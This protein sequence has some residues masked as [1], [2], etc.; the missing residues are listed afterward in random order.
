MPTGLQIN[1]TTGEI[2]GTPTVEQTGTDATITATNGVSPDDSVTISFA[3]VVLIAP[4]FVPSTQPSVTSNVGASFTLDLNATGNPA[5]TYS[6]TNLPSG[7]NIDATTGLISGTFTTEQTRTTTITASNGVSPDATVSIQFTVL[8]ALAAPQ[9]TTVV[10]GTQTLRTNMLYELQLEATGFPTSITWGVTSGTLPNNVILNTAT[11]EIRGTP[12]TDQSASAVVITASNGVSPDATITITFEVVTRIAPAFGAIA[13]QMLVVNMPYT[14]TL[15]VT[16]TPTPVVTEQSQFLGRAISSANINLAV[17][18]WRGGTRIGDRIHFVRDT[19]NVTTAYDFN[20]GRQSSDDITLTGASSIRGIVSTDDRIYV[21]S[22]NGTSALAFNHSGGRVSGDDIDLS[23]FGTGNRW[24]GATR[25]DSLIYFVDNIDD[26]ARAYNFDRTRSAENDISLGEGAWRS[27]LA[28]RDRIY[29]LNDGNIEEAQG[30]D[31]EGNRQTGF[32]LSFVPGFW[33]ASAASD[34][35]MWFVDNSTDIAAAYISYGSALP[36]GVTY[37]NGVVSGTPT[38]V[39]QDVDITFIATNSSGDEASAT[40]SFEVAPTPSAPQITAPTITSYLYP[41]GSSVALD[42]VA[43][44]S[45]QVSLWSVTSGT[46]PS[47]LSFSSTSGN[48]VQIVGTVDTIYPSAEVVITASN[49]VDPDATVNIQ[50]TVIAALFAPQFVPA[51]QPAFTRNV[52]DEFTLDLNATG[53]PTPTYSS[54]NLPNGLSIDATTGVITGTFATPQTITSTITATNSE[55]TDTVTISF[56]V[57]ALV[58]PSLAAVAAQSYTIHTAITPVTLQAS[59][60]PT[61]VI[62]ERRGLPQP[63]TSDFGLSSG[64]WRGAARNGNRIYF[65]RTGSTTLFAYDLQ[66]GRQLGDDITVTGTNH[67]GLVFTD[68]RIFLVDNA[69]STAFAFDHSG[70]EVVGDNINIG[71]GGWAGASRR[72]DRIYFLDN[73][74]NVIRVYT[75]SGARREAEDITVQNRAYRSILALDDVI[76]VIADSTNNAYPYDYSGAA[77]TTSLDLGEGS[78]HG[79]VWTPNHQIFFVNAADNTAHAY[80]DGSNLP[81]GVLINDGVIS[82]TPTAVFPTTTATFQAKNNVLP[83]ATIDVPFTVTAALS[84]PQITTRTFPTQ[85]YR[86]GDVFPAIDVNATGN[87]VPTWSATNLPPGLQINTTTGV[88]TGT[89]TALYATAQATITASN[90]VG[91]DDSITIEFTVVDALFAPTIPADAQTSYQLYRTTPFTLDLD[92][93]GATGNPA[94]TWS[95][96]GGTLPPGLN[97]SGTTLSGTPTTEGVQVVTFTASN[98]VSPSA[99]IDITFTVSP[100]LVAPNI[101]TTPF[102]RTLRVG[103]TITDI[104]LNATGNPAPDWSAT[105]L[106]PGLTFSPTTGNNV[107]ITGTPTTQQDARQA[108]ITARNSVDSDT[109]SVNFTVLVAFSV[110]VIASDALTSYNFVTGDEIDDIVIR[111]TGNPLPQWSIISGQLPT[112]VE[113]GNRRHLVCHNKGNAY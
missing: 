84:A 39:G 12:D 80:S 46:L 3:V 43:T 7:L 20:G 18:V 40:V 97:F 25:T 9:I 47:G 63:L 8:A 90:G 103:Q 52:G 74:N 73:A 15:P 113:L 55:D 85:S 95:H 28:L 51:T 67:E 17:G 96:T 6:A 16:G 104:P 33:H 108:T 89:F 101:T 92:D 26:V 66:G 2:T 48:A 21:F 14:Y 68:T 112:G 11:G 59:G 77:Q 88:I 57:N 49:G 98:G 44:A 56:T 83:D 22:L 38:V 32:D 81:R 65:V 13:P 111:V 60:N 100:P 5:P 106:P 10:T 58:S 23:S 34:D 41:L 62:S 31:L 79:S 45:P 37:A 105:N 69:L 19:T 107:V 94:P 91:S 82:G 42:L 99:S 110:P 54:P 30:W 78:W 29:F 64:A 86:I 24:E 109:L 71:S 53:N 50:F 70:T 4:Q 36:T 35:R 72:G 75:T 61:P 87:P 102:T 93:L 76:Y 27:A 1:P